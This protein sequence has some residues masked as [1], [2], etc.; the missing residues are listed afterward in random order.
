[1]LSLRAGEPLSHGP[2]RTL[3]GARASQALPVPSE[4]PSQAQ[5]R[6]VRHAIR[7]GGAH[8][9]LPPTASPVR[10]ISYGPAQAARGNRCHAQGQ[11]LYLPIRQTCPTVRQSAGPEPF[12]TGPSF[13]YA[14]LTECNWLYF[15]VSCS[16]LEV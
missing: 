16:C 14:E 11:C 8:L 7:H 4:P 6:S 10:Y 5:A 12:H 1:M 15:V 13:R 2:S 3:P 9:R